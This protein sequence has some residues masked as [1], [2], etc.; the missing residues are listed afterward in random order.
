MPTSLIDDQNMNTKTLKIIFSDNRGPV[1][2]Y[3]HDNNRRVL[4]FVL[5]GLT[6]QAES[7]LFFN[8]GI[9]TLH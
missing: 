1:L 9:K 2:G 3:L 6:V 8:T 4:I 7:G 5:R